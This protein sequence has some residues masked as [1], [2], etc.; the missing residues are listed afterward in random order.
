[1]GWQWNLKIKVIPILILTKIIPSVHETR[2]LKTFISSTCDKIHIY[3]YIVCSLN[4]VFSSFR[5]T[6]S[7]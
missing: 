7:C 3:E 2:Y 4:I 6:G 5:I 1:M